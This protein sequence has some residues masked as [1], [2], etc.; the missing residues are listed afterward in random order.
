MES[1]GK[2]GKDVWAYGTQKDDEKS[3]LETVRRGEEREESLADIYTEHEGGA[4]HKDREKAADIDREVYDENGDL[5][6]FLEIKTRSC[7]L[8]GYYKT[9][10]PFAKITS[11][12]ELMEEHDVPVHIALKFPECWA[13]HKLDPEIDYEK[14]D[15]PFAPA[16]RPGQR[17]KERQKPVKIPV[18]DLEVLPW[19]DECI[20]LDGT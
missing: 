6:Y 16:Y 3:Q 15:T 7:S 18:T 1:C 17:T 10:F 12:F 19:R 14:G 20:E 8:N 9:M 2:C 11:G 13:R 4:T 5:L